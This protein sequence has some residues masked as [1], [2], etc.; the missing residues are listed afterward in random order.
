VDFYENWNKFEKGGQIVTWLDHLQLG[1]VY[2][3]EPKL[4]IP[5]HHF[6]DSVGGLGAGR[7][8]DWFGAGQA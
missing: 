8:L 2:P 1:G 7:W 3:T 4:Y 6:Q 5:S